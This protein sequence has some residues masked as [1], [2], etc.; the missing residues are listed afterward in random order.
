MFVGEIAKAK[1]IYDFSN[2]FIHISCEKS[3]CSFVK[4]LLIMC[5]TFLAVAEPNNNNSEATS[6]II[7]SIAEKQSLSSLSCE[8]SE[9]TFRGASLNKKRIFIKRGSTNQAS[10]YQ[11][12]NLDNHYS[13]SKN[14][15]R[16]HNGIRIYHFNKGNAFLSNKMHEIENIVSNHRPHILGISEGNYFQNHDYDS[17]QIEN[18]K[19]ITSKTLENPNL[20]VS[21]CLLAQFNGGESKI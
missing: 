7:I 20:K 11:Y 17:V 13:K 2:M 21:V 8:F 16:K 19:F 10:Y 3:L 18:Y 6:D 1:I 14:G 5:V 15:N 4:W 12:S 9:T